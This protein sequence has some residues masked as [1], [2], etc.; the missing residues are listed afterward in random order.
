M[1]GDEALEGIKVFADTADINEMKRL[2]PVVKG[3]TTNPTLMRRAGVTDYKSWG[4]EVCVTF[5]D[6]CLSFEVLSNTPKDIIR[7]AEVISK[8]GQNVYVKVPILNLEGHSNVPVIQTLHDRGVQVNVTAVSYVDQL[9]GLDYR[10]TPM[11][12]SVFAGRIA[13]TGLDPIDEVI[14]ILY[15]V[16]D[17][18]YVDVLW[19]STR[20]VY[21]VMDALT[22]GADIIT[23]TPDLL[24]KLTAWWGK[25]LDYVTMETVRQFD[26]D[27][28]KAGYTL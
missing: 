24:D 28:K 8:W 10:D 16:E 7:E 20:Q 19:A 11:I 3:F 22:A 9:E 26:A 12:V 5:P 25:S 4:R 21:S 1:T 27:I 17:Y 18:P 6:H 14:D 2:S 15:E 23:V 13:D